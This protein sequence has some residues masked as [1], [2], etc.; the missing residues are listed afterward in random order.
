MT[1]SNTMAVACNEKNLIFHIENTLRASAK[2][3]PDFS[4]AAHLA[5]CALMAQ[6]DRFAHEATCAVCLAAEMVIN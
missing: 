6:R 5:N 4:R 3:E 2:S 1:Q